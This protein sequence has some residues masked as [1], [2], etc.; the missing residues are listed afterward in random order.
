MWMER[1]MSLFFRIDIGEVAHGFSFSE[2]PTC[3]SNTVEVYK[4]DLKA[5]IYIKAFMS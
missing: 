1:R 2:L 3:N 4:N 5:R